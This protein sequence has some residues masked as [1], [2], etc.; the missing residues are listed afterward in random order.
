VKGAETCETIY[1]RGKGGE[2][3][4]QKASL[5]KTPLL[6][7]SKG[8]FV[9]GETGMKG[10]KR[11]LS[12]ERGEEST[13]SPR[14]VR[15]THPPTCLPEKSEPNGAEENLLGGDVEREK[16][17]A[18]CRTEKEKEVLGVAFTQEKHNLLLLK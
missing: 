5:I 8:G 2:G 17:G 13:R 7:L 3:K 15:S 4:G 18:G 12:G 1:R 11:L 6:L 16:G 14:K 9:K 10:I